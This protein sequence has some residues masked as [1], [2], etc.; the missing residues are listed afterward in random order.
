[1]LLVERKHKEWFFEWLKPWIH[2]IPVKKD[3]SDLL[4]QV[5][6]IKDNYMTAIHIAKSAADF[7]NE[8]CT[9]DAAFKQWDKLIR[10]QRV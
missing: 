7:A 8:H 3:L 2:Y 9:R 5:K 6:W 10:N 4:I 1:M